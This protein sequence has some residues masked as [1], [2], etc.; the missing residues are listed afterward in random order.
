MR[1]KRPKL[2]LVLDEG[3]PDS[4]GV[5]FKEASHTVIY[6]NKELLRGTTDQLVC[7]FAQVNEAILVALDGDMKA[8]ARGIGLGNSRFKTLNLIKLSCYEPRA[9]NRVRA[10][11]SLI[12]HE[13]HVGANFE[14]RRLYVE[15]SDSVI[16][17]WR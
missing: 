12:E 6:C 7:A 4:V 5:A 2:K 8:I 13:W 10:S 9:E 14:G 11:M 3:V 15:I 17:S 1:F 16:R